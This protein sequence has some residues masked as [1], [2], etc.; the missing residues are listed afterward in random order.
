[1]DGFFCCT[2]EKGES[3]IDGSSKTKTLGLPCGTMATERKSKSAD[4][5]KRI[6]EKEVAEERVSSTEE[7]VEKT[8]E[9]DDERVNHCAEKNESLDDIDVEFLF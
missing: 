7:G 3:L 6:S 2:L 1:M 5:C 9:P 4:P 8:R